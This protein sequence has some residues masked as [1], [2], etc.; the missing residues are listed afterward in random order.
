M[1]WYFKACEHEH[2][3]KSAYKNLMKM[4]EALDYKAD[5]ILS[6]TKTYP[7]IDLYKLYYHIGV[8]FS[9]NNNPSEAIS[10]FQM[11]EAVNNK[12]FQLMNLMAIEYDKLKDYSNVQKSYEKCIELN[13]RF[14]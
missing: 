10:W 3:Y 1:N 2:D 4:F 7:K 5:D 13:P 12:D 6:A 8:N 9:E 11:A 14:G